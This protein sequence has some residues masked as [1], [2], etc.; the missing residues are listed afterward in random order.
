MVGAGIGT[1][2]LNGL[3]RF[4][5]SKGIDPWNEVR[6]DLAFRAPR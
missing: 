6:F 1:S 5:L 2:L 4:D 3:I